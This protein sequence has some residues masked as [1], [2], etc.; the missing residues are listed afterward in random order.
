MTR[1]KPIDPEFIDAGVEWLRSYEPAPD[2]PLGTDL[3]RLADWLEGEA[4]RIR[5]SNAITFICEQTGV[6]RREA[7][8]QLEAVMARE[9]LKHF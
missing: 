6:G 4:K 2:D 9:E 7:R 3:N 1:P 8:K 5:E